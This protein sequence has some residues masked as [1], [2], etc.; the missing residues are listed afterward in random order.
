[1]ENKKNW[2]VI[3]KNVYEKH[4][5]DEVHLYGLLHQLAA[6]AERIRDE[7][8]VFHLL[9]TVKK[10]G[11]TADE[12][13]DGWGIPGRYLVFGEKKDLAALK[14]E[15][16][17]PEPDALADYGLE[18]PAYTLTARTDSGE[19]TTLLLGSLDP[20]GSHRYAM[21]DGGTEV[22]TVDGSITSSLDS[23]LLDLMELPQ[24]PDLDEKNITSAQ[25]ELTDGTVRQLTSAVETR[26]TEVE[27]ETGETDENREP[28]YETTTETE[29]ITL[30]SLDGQPLPEGAVGLEDWLYDLSTLYLDS[31]S[32]FKADQE[33]LSACGMDGASLL[34]VSLTSGETFTL[35][36]GGQTEDGS[37]VYAALEAP[38]PGCD[39]FLISADKARTLSDLNYESLSA[40]EEAE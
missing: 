5:D 39:L 15:R 26:E 6:Q 31:C 3:G 36:I 38:A 4:I 7:E 2:Y 11:A 23:E 35:A 22:Y 10:Y 16:I 32:A 30:W 27:T 13:F 18:E 17:I 19:S 9:D 21:L 8:D 12:M 24:L 1:M 14:A 33:E 40:D 34:T 28:I 20:G 37:Y 25:L 29:E